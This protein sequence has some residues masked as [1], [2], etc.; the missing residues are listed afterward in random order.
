MALGPFD[1]SGGPFL[2]LYAAL[3]L[4]AS[5]LSIRLSQALRPEG[6]QPSQLDGE[7]MAVLAGGLPRHCELLAAQLL[8]SGNLAVDGKQR[9]ALASDAPATPAVRA[10][11]GT[12]S[13]LDWATVERAFGA[14]GRAIRSRLVD[15]GLLLADGEGW[16]L[17]IAQAL[18]FVLLAG[19]GLIKLGIGEAR[20]RPVGFL[21]LALIV[22]VVVAVIRFAGLDMRTRAGQAALAQARERNDRLRRAPTAGEVGLGVALFGTTVLAG[23][24]WE[25]LHRL[26]TA[27]SDN[28]SGG[29]DSSSDGGSSGG[30]C[31]GGG[32]GG[33]ST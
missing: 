23:S 29:S 16:R 6:R 7:D 20:G 5:I 31:G 24:Q 3:F 2:L 27:G 9:L 33:C 22:T 19:F 30:G 18:P 15:H 1:L 21:L 26:R 11:R 10:L 13:P 8:A 4:L 25:S 12:A 28:G 14:L 32:C 17:R